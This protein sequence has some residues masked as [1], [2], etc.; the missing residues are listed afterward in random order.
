[1]KYKYKYLIF[2]EKPYNQGKTV[3]QINVSHLNKRDAKKK[4]KELDNVYSPELYHSSLTETN[5][6]LI[7]F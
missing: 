1:M 3:A 7:E 5:E 6:Q 4:W 2:R